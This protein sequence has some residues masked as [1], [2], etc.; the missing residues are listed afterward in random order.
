M[1]IGYTRQAR[2]DDNE[3][4]EHQRTKITRAFAID[5]WYSDVAPGSE[6]GRKGLQELIT[7]CERNPYPG[8]ADNWGR[9]VASSADRIGASPK[10]L[11]DLATR[12]AR[13]GWL[14]VSLE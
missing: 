8:S 14:L 10:W 6:I 5:H 3:T 9:V 4:H 12:L 13:H 2:P 7:F 1:N 11:I